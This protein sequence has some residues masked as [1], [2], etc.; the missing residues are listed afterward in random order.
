M[1]L[2]YKNIKKRR[3]ELGMSQEELARLTG[4]TSRTSIA[5]I[6]S[7]KVDIPLSK[8]EKF[9]KALK[10]KPIE[11]MDLKS[12]ILKNDQLREQVECALLKE[13]EEKFTKHGL[14]F[15]EE[16]KK[17]HLETFRQILNEMNPID[18]LLDELK[19]NPKIYDKIYDYQLTS[20]EL[21]EFEKIKQMNMLM[22]N[23][24]EVSEANMEKLNNTLKEI[25]IQSLIEKRKKE[26]K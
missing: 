13:T 15:N 20:D 3:E 10:I 24:K 22:F 17:I 6:E 18:I 11:L 14:S 23:G 8:I 21:I 19:R 16:D 9:S 12:E 1:G 26:K 5:K 4:Y 2:L 25:F 7:G